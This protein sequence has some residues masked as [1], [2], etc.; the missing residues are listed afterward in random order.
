MYAE[1]TLQ[2]AEVREIMEIGRRNIC[3]GDEPDQ[4]RKGE[5]SAGDSDRHYV[6][7]LPVER[8]MTESINGLADAHVHWW[9]RSGNDQD[10]CQGVSKT[11]SVQDVQMPAEL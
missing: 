10:G 5:G 8:P 1:S 6:P 11:R 4:I 9:T 3:S 2:E 7:G